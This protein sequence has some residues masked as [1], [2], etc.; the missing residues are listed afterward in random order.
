LLKV[1]SAADELGMDS[2]EHGCDG[3]RA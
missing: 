2:G 3:E 1:P